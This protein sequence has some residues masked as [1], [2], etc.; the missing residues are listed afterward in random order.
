MPSTQG[1]RAGRAFVELFADDS[2][3]VRGLRAAEKKLKAFGQGIRNLGLKVIGIG[4][5]ILAPLA[6]SAKVFSGYGD[7]IAKM[8]KRTGLSVEALSELQFVASQTGTDIDS[9]E[10]GVRRMQRTIYDAERGLSTAVDA[11]KDLGLTAADFKG[12]SP[13]A[14]FKLL[15]EQISKVEDPSRRAAL[16]MTI[17]GRS[18]TAL[19]PMFASGAK[20]IEVLQ[21]QA[22]RLGLTMSGEDAQAAEDFTDAMDRLWKTIRIGMFN[23]GAALA[24]LL[25]KIANTITKVVVSAGTWIKANRQ[26]IVTV[27]KVAAI[28]IAVGAALVV[29]GVLISGLGSAI[30]VLITVITAVGAVFNI[31]A[32]VIAFLLSPIGA[33]IAAVVALGAYLVYAT[34]IGGKALTWLGDRFG[35]LKDTAMA[36]FG[37]IADALAAGDIALAARILW[38][39]LKLAWQAGIDQLNR[40]W[41]TFKSGFLKI[42][43]EA[44]YGA[45]A[46]LEIATHGLE[47]AWIETTAFLSKTWTSFTAGFQKAWGGAVDWTTKRLLELQGLFDDTFDV[48]Q[49]KRL[50]DQQSEA[51]N[52]N[53][54][55]QRDATLAAREQERQQQRDQSKQ[56][57]E[58]TLAQIGSEADASLKAINTEAAAKRKTTEDA[59]KQARDEFQK[60]V[61]EARQKRQTHDATGPG[62]LEGPDSILDKARRA[63]A[64]LGDI[65]DTI[66]EQ[67]D[68]IGVRGTFNASP[69]SLLGLQSGAKTQDRIAKAAEDT[70]KN[71]KRIEQAI[72]NHAIAFA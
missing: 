54:D 71:T 18:G 33:V 65:G 10:N 52:R 19:L 25:Q 63:L 42:A 61:D 46:A 28:V 56:L 26:V 2:R 60:A 30:G 70:A 24:P 57:H 7:Q 40:L 32:G 36:A 13:E 11:L 4:A 38:L 23:I 1:I 21:A 62:A 15:A 16:A 14:Q 49:A 45:I 17:F 64:G 69:A 43:S 68:K 47:V 34:G 20:G 53:I 27:A 51:D 67:A 6:A 29:L 66:K 58:A 41:L 72:N 48:D 9:L 3:L 44:F 8:A 37:G 12:L 31:L 5:A 50:V 22:R 55:Q 59:L 39:T 35:E